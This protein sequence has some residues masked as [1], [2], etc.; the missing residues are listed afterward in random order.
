[1]TTTDIAGMPVATLPILAIMKARA[2]SAGAGDLDDGGTGISIHTKG[3]GRTVAQ[4]KNDITD[5]TFLLKKMVETK[6]AFPSQ[7]SWTVAYIEMKAITESLAK[8]RITEPGV[9]L[10]HLQEP[11]VERK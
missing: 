1:M 4:Q 11:K 3:P 8:D 9:L 7:H 10:S 2:I 6:T 5:F